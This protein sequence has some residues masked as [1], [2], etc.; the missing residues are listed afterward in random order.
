ME[1]SWSGKKS[2]RMKYRSDKSGAKDDGNGDGKS[3][4]DVE[5]AY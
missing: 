5:S 4:I 3:A 2:R 1:Q